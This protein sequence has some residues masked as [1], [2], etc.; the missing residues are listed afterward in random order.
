DVLVTGTELKGTIFVVAEE[1]V[2]GRKEELLKLVSSVLLR[3]IELIIPSC[4][5]QAFHTKA[6]C[7]EFAGTGYLFIKLRACKY[8]IADIGTW[9]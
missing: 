5:R 2:T 1:N 7:I 6:I 4:I 8:R 9:Y 3:S